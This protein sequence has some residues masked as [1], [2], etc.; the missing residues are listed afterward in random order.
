MLHLVLLPGLGST[1][2]AY[3]HTQ[4]S[5]LDGVELQAVDYGVAAN[6]SIAAMASSAWAQVRAPRVVLLGYSMGG[7]VAQEMVCQQPARVLGVI[8]VSTTAPTLTQVYDKPDELRTLLE[9]LMTPDARAGGLNPRVLYSASFLKQ[10][11]AAGKR[12]LYGNMKRG[13]LPR[14][15]FLVQLAAVTALMTSNAAPRRLACFHGVPV[16]V[17][18]GGQDVLVPPH[19]VEALD[20]LRTDGMYSRMTFPDAG[21]ALLIEQPAH[22]NA[23]ITQFLLPL[24]RAARLRALGSAP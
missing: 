20:V 5:K 18:H 21:H 7:F 4:L 12:R 9:L 3:G 23:L 13:A 6:H 15:Q 16:L 10:L 24:R 1:A 8:L 11:T 22:T 2:A 17:L 14:A 19:A